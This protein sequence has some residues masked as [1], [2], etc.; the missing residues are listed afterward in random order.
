MKKEKKIKKKAYT[1]PRIVVEL[2]AMEEGIATGSAKV[3]PVNKE[4]TIQESWEIGKD[5]TM[6]GKW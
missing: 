3:N 6:N 5:Q 1:A 2:I 4:G